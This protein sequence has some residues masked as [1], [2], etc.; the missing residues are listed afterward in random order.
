MRSYYGNHKQYVN[1]V[2]TSKTLKD[3]F[4]I[5]QNF[6]FMGATVFEIAGG[7]ADPRTPWYKVWVPKGL[8]E[9][10]V[11]K[12]R[13]RVRKNLWFCQYEQSLIAILIILLSSVCTKQKGVTLSFFSLVVVPKPNS[14]LSRF[15]P[16]YPHFPRIK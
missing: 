13:R 16:Y 9:G 5:L 8:A 10:R 2:N 15:R 12:N 4:N 11:K 1:N 14:R 3:F 7:P 6:K